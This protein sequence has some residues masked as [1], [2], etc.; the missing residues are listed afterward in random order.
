[1]R[2]IFITAGIIA[3]LGVVMAQM[4]TYARRYRFF[5]K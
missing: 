4:G 5:A 3:G 2:N 1:M